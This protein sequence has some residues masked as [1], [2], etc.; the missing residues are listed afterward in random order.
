[1][2]GIDERI[3][4]IKFDNA[5]FERNI[6]ETL[7]SLEKLRTS[8]DFSNSAKGMNELANVSSRF[9][10]GNV[11][12]SIESVSGKF[13]ALTT[14]GITAL[15]TLTTHAIQAGTRIVKGLSIAPVLDGFKEYE[16]NI[17][18]IQT[19][20]AN[21][22][23]KG[24]TL[25]QVN[26]A[27]DQLNQY[28]D[29]T[30][31][32]FS[33]MARNIGTF[34][35]AGVDLDTSVNSIKGIANIA[36]I[37]G[38]SS[39]QAST[40]MYQLSQAIAAGSVKLQDWNSVVNAG[41]GGEVF[42]K[43]LF[44]TAKSLGTIKNVPMGQTFEQWKASGNSFRLSLEQGWLTSKVLTTTLSAFTG[45]M[46]E[47]QLQALG[48][49][50]AQAAE[51]MK[52][53]KLGKAAATEV[54]T[55]T[56]LIS[57]VKEAVG[58]GW[59]TS[60]RTVIGDFEEAKKLFTGL[61]NQIGHFVGTSADA[62]NKVL[63]DWKNLGGRNELLQGL[64]NAFWALT[65]PLIAIGKGFRD[66][67]PPMTGERLLALTKAFT[68]FMDRITIS[69]T[70]MTRIQSIFAGFFGVVEI[71]WTILKDIV[72]LIGQVLGSLSGVG[73]G[74]LDFAAHIG[75]T[76]Y[77][78][79]KAL[80]DGG[81][82]ARFFEHLGEVIKA[83]G[84]FIQQL[85]QNIIDFFRG[86]DGSEKV[87][88]GLA[89]LEGRFDS[90]SG[91]TKR[92]T[93]IWSRLNRFFEG[94]K[95]VLDSI[96]TYIRGW[97]SDLGKNLAAAMAPGDFN[98]AVDVVNVG[99]LG[100]IALILKKF[101]RGGFKIDFGGGL[102]EKVAKSFDTLTGTLK[103]MQANVRAD[104]L[105]KIAAAVGVLTVSVTVLSL[106]NSEAL[107]K[108][109]VALSVGFGQLVGTMALLDKV[110]SGVGSAVKIGVLSGAMIL[111]AGAMVI[112]S[113][114]VKNL[115]SLSWGELAKGLLGV[116]VMLAALTVS[117]NL[118]SA[119][120]AG[121]IRAGIA[122]SAMAVAMLILSTAV[123]SFSDLSWG[124]LVKGLT[125]VAIGLGLLTVA[126]NF[127]P[128]G[129]LLTGLGLIGIATG[130][131]ILAEA[132]QAF[133]GIG[134]AEMAKGFVGVGTGLLIIAGAMRLMPISLPITAAGL[135]ILSVALNVI[136]AAVRNMGNAELTQL[137]K[138]L[139]AF[140]AMLLI[141]AVA[142]NAMTG[143]MGGAL[144]LVVVSGALLVLSHVL[145]VL[146]E[147]KISELATGLGAIAAVLL[148]LGVAAAV[149]TPVVPALLSL[150]AA[151]A[152]IGASFALFG[153]GAYLVAKA[154]EALAKAGK[155]GVI[156]LIDVIKLFIKALPEFVGAFV[157]SIVELAGEIINAAPF[158]LKMLTVLLS[159]MLDTV[160]Q[161]TPKIGEAFGAII[162]TALKL[163][164]EKF[165]D[166]I[167]TGFQLFEQLLIGMRNNMPNIIA[168][169]VNAII[170]FA[171]AMAENA[172]RLVDAGIQVLTAFLNAISNRIQDVVNAGANVILNFILGIADNINK[173]A[174]T[175][176]EI[177]A[178]F[179]R[180]MAANTQS[181]ITSGLD[182]MLDFLSGIS[183]N[184]NRV[185]NAAGEI[186]IAFIRGL[187]DNALKF[188]R[189]A[190]DVLINFLNGLAD[191]IR[192]NTPRLMDAGRNIAGAIIDGMIEG[193]KD[194]PVVG[195][196]IRLGESVI[197][198]VKGVF[199]SKSPSK[200]FMRIGRDVG[201]GL[202]IG[203]DRDTLAENSAVQ[204]AERI[205]RAFQDTLSKSP[206]VLSGMGDLSPVITP[207]LDLTKVQLASRNLDQ[208]LS[209]S[210]ISPSV[211]IS[212]ARV[213]SKTT[214]LD[215]TDNSP[216]D[217][218]PTEIKFE[219]NIY[220]PEALST[221][222]I[223][224]N[225]KS[226]IATAKEKLGIS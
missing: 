48:Y 3:T 213:I 82:I 154:F 69:G 52:L 158:L 138:G 181:F 135:L 151:L 201:Q 61:S 40:A 170:S 76:L 212:Q 46:N 133:G 100:G 71:G 80:V 173:M 33:E 165:P 83:P 129:M 55:F 220:S 84:V 47:A 203:L 128:P 221:N 104:T 37:S 22:S 193:L 108:A 180:E 73:G 38:S 183:N 20:L 27:L 114:A 140:A 145:K 50:K 171:A 34:T 224:R 149:L 126:M 78:L 81:G 219:Q 130:M 200:V 42:Q 72:G 191:A 9:N 49:T 119:N 90:L 125:G 107:T 174:A 194:T 23:S 204:H 113:V 123:K 110:A 7:R 45:D 195:S 28:S 98:A 152:L 29:Q 214:D 206:D 8:L 60:F 109:M 31:Y 43:A 143:A 147:L 177:A 86:F 192:E 68:A 75:D 121:I 89:R 139:G 17:G 18:S 150:G 101:L 36:A 112:L 137:A 198:A 106:I 66:I 53:G 167:Q 222:D 91:V 163:M 35:A 189:A 162:T 127:M 2:S 94:F 99:L 215:P 210:S 19:I 199:Q 131:R 115:S 65:R 70:T 207:V 6:G 124:E 32:N 5:S 102:L 136:A 190:F 218:I 74:A 15:A 182:V 211:S 24:T 39:E 12:N 59:S 146:G 157:K 26:K 169:G 95:N 168:L 25:D 155:A 156:A 88:A 105:L 116:T 44:D 111:L 160:I 148:L 117:M 175:V 185:I 202:A 172:V 14:V 30:I 179:V 176:T 209:V 197:N 62:R 11:G 93:D 4:S 57:T 21:T 13:L 54:K 161:L 85:K 16:T 225:T 144:A 51:M 226:Q 41:M 87:E 118:I 187:G 205:V 67:F 159:Q 208:L 97:F 223:Y 196:A 178:T 64:E 141:L 122:M 56:Q 184:I 120:M 103:A 77:D 132:V 79:N 63:T 217:P 10:L 186:A 1:M 92:F 134:W 96:W 58:S 166:I 153:T 188:A 142:M 216:A 164:R